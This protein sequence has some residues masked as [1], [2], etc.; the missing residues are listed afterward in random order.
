M[1]TIGIVSSVNLIAGAGIL[2][3]VGGTAL[4]V[5]TALTNSISSYSSVPVVS[6]FAD[7]VSSGIAATGNAVVTVNVVASTF[8]A[9]T[10]AIPTAYQSSL[11]SASLTSTVSTEANNIFGNGDLGKFEQVLGAA[12]ALVSQTNQLINSSVNAAKPTNTIAYTTQDNLITGGFSSVTQAFSAFGKDLAHLGQAIDLKDLNNLGS[13]VAL[14]RQINTLSGN[15]PELNN[16]LL[17]AGLPQYAVEDP[18]TA[19]FT[20]SQQRIIYLAMTEITGNTLAQILKILKVTT[21]GIQNLAE[22]LN[23]VKIFPNSFNTL[24]MPTKNGLRG[25]YINSTGA[26]N[27]G[28]ATQL[29]ANILSSYAQLRQIIPADQALANKALQNGLEQIKTIFDAALPALASASVNLESNVGLNAI[30]ALTQPLPANVLAYFTET[31]AYGTGP[32]GTLLLTDVIGS[33][34]GWDINDQLANTAT[35]LNTM[36]SEGDFVAL[37]NGSTGVYT[38]MTNT[39]NGDYT[40]SVPFPGSGFNTTIPS[41]KPGAGSYY[42]NTANA[43]IGNAFSSGLNPA[44]V[45]IVGTI[46]AANPTQVANTTAYFNTIGAQLTREK[47]NL[48]AADTVFA[49]LQPGITP[50]GLVYGLNSYG[51]DTVKGGAAYIFDNI[52]VTANISGQAVISTMREA[53]N[54]ARLNAIGIGTDIT[55]SQVTAE[56]QANLGTTQ[57]TVSQATSQK[58]L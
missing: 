14:L 15:W 43:S 24:T 54:Q 37:T 5:S 2:G 39:I 48:A 44:M 56:P 50:W 10:D 33:V 13:P 20:D 53:R 1:S 4:A 21:A 35:I 8:P 3:N 52:A 7:I 55:I 42:G 28:L 26:I 40:S 12:Q 47:N 51:L 27:T 32:N 57:Y 30:N 6:Q 25:I 58:I 34:V 17:A 31:L 45:S 16:K 22:L 23:P 9:L 41:G 36:T 46:V 18:E 19:T 38:I 29:P 11:G 49:N